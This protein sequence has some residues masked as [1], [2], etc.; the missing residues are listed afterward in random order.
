MISEPTSLFHLAGLPAFVTRTLHFELVGTSESSFDER[1]GHTGGRLPEMHHAP[2][3]FAFGDVAFET[4]EIGSIRVTH[5][6]DDLDRVAALSLQALHQQVFSYLMDFH[7]HVVPD[8]AGL[9]RLSVVWLGIE[10]DRGEIGGAAGHRSLLVNYPY[11]DDAA[12]SINNARTLLLVAHEQTHQLHDYMRGDAPPLP[13]W[14]SESLAHFSALSALMRSGL[15]PATTAELASI[16]IDVE[17]PI[18]AG[19]LELARRHAMGDPEAYGRF[20]TQGATFWSEVD[21]ILRSWPSR[22][23]GLAELLPEIIRRGGE[24]ENGS[25]LLREI[26]DAHA[27]PEMQALIERY[28]GH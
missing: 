5:V 14:M 28:V 13:A 12:Q 4:Q 10:A 25:A 22:A 1:P 18:D 16:F 8:Q 26:L 9:G 21:R 15:P 11:G 20:Y 23:G 27:D 17:R 2:E 3:F 19:L 24:L 6:L 7:G